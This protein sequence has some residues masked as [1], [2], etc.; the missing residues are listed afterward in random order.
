MERLQFFI[1]EHICGTLP[2]VRDLLC[3]ALLESDLNGFTLG[4]RSRPSKCK[5]ETYII[6][7]L[8]LEKSMQSELWIFSCPPVQYTDLETGEPRTLPYTYKI[9]TGRT[10]GSA[11]L[12]IQKDFASQ[13][14]YPQKYVNKIHFKELVPHTAIWPHKSEMSVTTNDEII[15][16]YLKEKQSTLRKFDAVLLLNIYYFTNALVPL[17]LFLSK[18]SH[19]TS[20]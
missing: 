19:F 7:F 13:D 18:L 5:H 9:S 15:R 12:F 10:Y 4:S 2:E 16:T 1:H 3:F 8:T 11:V 14:I 17:T 6:Q 20:K